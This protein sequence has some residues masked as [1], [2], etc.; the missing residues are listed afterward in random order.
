[1]AD[2]V[3]SHFPRDRYTTFFDGCFGTGAVTL[4][5]DPE[6]KAEVACDL[7]SILVTFWQVLRDDKDRER[8]IRQLSLTPFSREEFDTAVALLSDT[9]AMGSADRVEIARSVI[10]V[11]RQSM[12]G[13]NREFTPI[14]TSRLRRGMNE[15]VSSWLS[16]IAPD[17]LVPIAERLQS[18]LLEHGDCVSR[19]KSLDKPGVLQYFDLPYIMSSRN[20]GEVYRQEAGDDVHERL[21]KSVTSYKHALVVVS[22]NPHALYDQYLGGWRTDTMILSNLS[23]KA[24]IKGDRVEKL[25]MNYDADGNRLS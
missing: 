4:A 8:L 11:S 12:A 15:Q 22:H 24:D 10:V 5:H 17:F 23:A 6:G 18:I 7:D 21:L 14:T 9:E 20:S 3:V 19:G 1:M 25:W 13:R 16:A 2:W